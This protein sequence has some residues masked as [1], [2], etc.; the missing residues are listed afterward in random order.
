[1]LPDLLSVG[2]REAVEAPPIHRQR[3]LVE[4]RVAGPPQP[5]GQGPEARLNIELLLSLGGVEVN[6]EGRVEIP[7]DEDRR[8][9]PS[10]LMFEEISSKMEFKYEK[11]GNF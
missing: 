1:V 11:I 7:M 3:Q 6:L 4:E 8:R 5:F 10:K 2:R 9:A